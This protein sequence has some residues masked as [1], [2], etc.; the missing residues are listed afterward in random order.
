MLILTQKI[1]VHFDEQRF[2]SDSEIYQAW[3]NLNSDGRE[4]FC[5]EM[6]KAGYEIFYD[7]TVLIIRRI[8]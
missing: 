3:R 1:L 5:K 8:I 7:Q 2:G 4:V 6:E